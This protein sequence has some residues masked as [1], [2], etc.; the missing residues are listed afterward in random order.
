MEEHMEDLLYW[1]AGGLGVPLINWLKQVFGV[2]GKAA[3]WLTALVALILALPAMLLT[4]QIDPEDVS[5]EKLPAVF[6]QVLTAAT[7][8]YKLLIA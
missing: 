2:R 4:R 3:M 6:A 8:V 5:P 7:L 1:L